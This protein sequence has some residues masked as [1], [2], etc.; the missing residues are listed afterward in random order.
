MLSFGFLPPF[1]L[2]MTTR[3]PA[4]DLNGVAHESIMQDLGIMMQQ[5]REAIKRQELL[6]G[7]KVPRFSG[8]D[9]AGWI[10]W[11]SKVF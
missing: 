10:E 6:L 5:L 7:V 2:N 9:P 11:Y 4:E 8:I 3:Q 1:I